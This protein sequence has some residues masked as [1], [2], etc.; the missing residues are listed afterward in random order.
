MVA[1][2]EGREPFQPSPTP[3]TP[4]TAETLVDWVGKRSGL[5]AA[6]HRWSLFRT[7]WW[8]FLAVAALLALLYLGLFLTLSGL[9]ANPWL[10][11]GVL[12]TLWWFRRGV[13]VLYAVPL[14]GSRTTVRQ[15]S[16]HPC[17]RSPHNTTARTLTPPHP[18]TLTPRSPYARPHSSSGGLF[19][20]IKHV[21]LVAVAPAGPG[22]PRQVHFFLDHPQMQ[23]GLEGYSMGACML[24]ASALLLLVTGEATPLTFVKL[25]SCNIACNLVHPFPHSR[26]LAHPPLPRTTLL[27]HPLPS[28]PP[29]H[30]SPTRV[31]PPSTTLPSIP[32]GRPQD[33]PRQTAHGG[34]G[35]VGGSGRLGRLHPRP[36]PPQGGAAHPPVRIHGRLRAG[37]SA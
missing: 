16:T 6:V 30:P 33:A 20:I 12:L 23:L 2:N 11:S 29:L 31:T 37:E 28:Y 26:P 5:R 13:G 3:Q 15:S 18:R 27:T 21:P 17:A 22:R 1:L 14:A 36:L 25:P 8:P 4:F 9:A 35:G 34:A 7:W 19:N 24:I 10:I 32:S